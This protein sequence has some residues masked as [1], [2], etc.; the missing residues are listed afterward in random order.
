MSTALTT[1][2]KTF[3]VQR[4][5]M[6]DGPSDVMEACR[7]N[8]GIEIPR[9][10]AIYYNPEQSPDLADKWRELHRTT[11]EQYLA[12]MAAIPIANQTH[13]LRELQDSFNRVKRKGNKNEA[14]L[15]SILEQ[16]A[17][18]AGGMF[19]NRRELTGKGG[20]PLMPTAEE[21]AREGFKLLV[22]KQGMSIED[23]TRIV[24]ERYRVAEEV[25]ISE[26]EN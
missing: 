5:A 16:A 4:F 1:E 7:E 2:Q 10:T 14:M 25:L 9:N 20:K 3:I 8:L 23:A 6:F 19:T 17:K 21:I 11:R 12:T 22:E 26:A 15:H 13:R 24:T 18:E